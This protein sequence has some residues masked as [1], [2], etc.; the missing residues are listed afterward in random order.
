[1]STKSMA[2]GSASSSTG[3]KRKAEE[4]PVREFEE[5]DLTDRYMEDLFEDAPYID[6]IDNDQNDNIDSDNNDYQKTPQQQR[7]AA[8]RSEY[9]S[10]PEETPCPRQRRHGPRE[11][12]T[13]ITATK[14]TASRHD[15]YFEDQDDT[16][17]IDMDVNNNVENVTDDIHEDTAD[18]IPIQEV[19]DQI[20]PRPSDLEQEEVSTMLDEVAF[21][22]ADLAGD[23]DDIPLATIR[24]TDPVI[25]REIR[26]AH[27]NLGHP[28][29]AILLK[30]IRRSDASDATQRYAS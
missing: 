4:T 12:E 2:S 17:Y 13:P 23:E 16:S 6:P 24:V 20:T 8:L 3:T 25:M 14:A 30:I 18:E 21:H 10:P 29:T 27:Y 22:G 19:E 5:R 7:P 11:D 28:F 1:M 15:H 9:R 26:N